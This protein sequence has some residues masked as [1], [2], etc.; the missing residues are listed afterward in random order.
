M[1]DEILRELFGE[2]VFGRLRQVA[3][4]SFSSGCSL[5][6]SRAGSVPRSL[7]DSMK[8]PPVLRTGGC[9][10]SVARDWRL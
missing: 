4:I 8:Q 5:V 3:P 9:S 1:V 10:N 7:Q 6:G 2:V